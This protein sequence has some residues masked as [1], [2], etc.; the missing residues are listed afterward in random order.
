MA[1]WNSK[2]IYWVSALVL[3]FLVGLAVLNGCKKAPPTTK[4]QSPTAGPVSAS[5]AADVAK[6]PIQAV[7]NPFGESKGSLEKAI[8]EAKTWGPVFDPW[9]GKIA[10]DFTLTDIQGNV[11]KLSN[12]RGKN[13]LVVFWATSCGPCKLE[14]PGLVKLRESIGQDKLA[15]L[16]ISREDQ[17]L[18]K[19]FV[20]QNPVNYTLLSCA[21]ATLPSPYGEVQNVPSAFFIDAEGKIKLATMGMIPQADA[22]KVLDAK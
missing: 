9:R 18:I 20:A 6:D 7:K 3:A 16:A 10:P 13:V 14:M 2:T 4:E 8:Q 17:A 19:S 22:V 21:G 11:H 1:V 5:K 12:Y 15:I